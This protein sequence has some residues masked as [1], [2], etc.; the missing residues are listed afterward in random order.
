MIKHQKKIKIPWTKMVTR[1]ELGPVIFGDGYGTHSWAIKG[2]APQ[3]FYDAANKHKKGLISR[4]DQTFS[5]VLCILREDLPIFEIEASAKF[6]YTPKTYRQ[7]FKLFDTGII[8]NVLFEEYDGV[9][10]LL[11]HCIMKGALTKKKS[12]ALLFINPET[13]ATEGIILSQ[14]DGNLDADIEIE[15]QTGVINS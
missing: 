2:V 15:R 3:E 12:K 5:D 4:N 6:E 13:S 7:G 9:S 14:W 8:F 10:K 11:P 1:S